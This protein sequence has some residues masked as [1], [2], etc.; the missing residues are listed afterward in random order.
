MTSTGFYGDQAEPTFGEQMD[1]LGTAKPAEFAAE[2]PASPASLNIG[3]TNVAKKMS[4]RKKVAFGAGGVLLAFL[5]L[6]VILDSA[7][8]TVNASPK[9]QAATPA[10]ANPGQMM[11]AEVASGATVMGG[12][13]TS[14]AAASPAMPDVA[15]QSKVAVP[16]P[17]Q[18]TQAPTSA[19]VAPMPSSAQVAATAIALAQ[20]APAAPA[21]GAAAAPA[22]PAAASLAA[23]TQT[24]R[25][26]PSSKSNGK[27]Q[28]GEKT[29]AP[30]VTPEQLALRV[31]V[32]ERRLARY[33]RGDAQERARIVKEA[34]ARTKPATSEKV[35]PVAQPF[36]E[37]KKPVVLEND[38]VRVV[39][40]STHHGVTSALVDYGGVK[41]RVA[42]GDSIPGLGTVQA[43]AADAAGN[44][45]VEI[46]GV[47]YQ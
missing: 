29:E 43:V 16:A 36:V 30:S 9:P 27:A 23:A 14:A 17:A 31:A 40:M 5:A 26:T 6:V 12:T 4:T 11:G 3:K 45:V 19:P 20:T 24:A 10:P 47:R 33:E 15:D 28:S 38:S 39:G 21:A 44:V 34:V 18:A 8:P 37:V 35:L 42:Q 22:T 32:L 46:N 2:K 13:P 41:K 7:Q 1:P 25:I